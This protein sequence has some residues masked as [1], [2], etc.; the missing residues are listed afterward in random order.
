MALS[1]ATR[2]PLTQLLLENYTLVSATHEQQNIGR[3]ADAL[4]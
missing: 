3:L 2:N 1:S 4:A